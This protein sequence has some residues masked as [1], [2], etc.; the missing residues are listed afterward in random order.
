MQRQ[1]NPHDT[2]ANRLPSYATWSGELDEDAD[3]LGKIDQYHLIKE[4]GAGGFG[5]VYLARD[6]ISGL[7]LAAKGLPPLV[8]V[9]PEELDNVRRNFALISTLHHPGIAAPL[10]LHRAR[11]VWYASEQTRQRMRVLEEDYLFIMS[12]APGVTLSTWRRHFPGGRVPVKQALAIGQQIASALDYAHS[13]RVIHRDIKPSNVMIADAEAKSDKGADIIARV[14]DFGLAAEVR[15]SMSRI[16]RDAGDT[17]GTRPYMAPEQWQGERQGPATDQYALAVLMYELLNGS[18]PF[19]SAFETGDPAVME[20]VICGRK[21]TSLNALNARQNNALLKA[22]AKKPEDRH[23]SCGAF[24]T[25]LSDDR[26][27]AVA[28]SRKAKKAKKSNF[29]LFVLAVLLY[30]VARSFMEATKALNQSVP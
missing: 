29:W 15:L 26:P 23:A 17:S 10:H 21:A 24:I 22:L 25:A 6:A 1:T 11:S 13:M 8:Q 30:F 4:L 27:K 3:V 2:I 19:A 5:Y 20:R 28:T 18:V 7:L 9:N 14:L 16:S 12:Y